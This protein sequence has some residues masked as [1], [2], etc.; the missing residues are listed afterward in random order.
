MNASTG[1][2][3]I[4]EMVGA[5][6]T[7][8]NTTGYGLIDINGSLS[9]FAYPAHTNETEADGINNLNQVVGEYND[10]DQAA[11]YGFLYVSGQYSLVNPA[12]PNSVGSGAFGINDAGWIVGTWW[13]S[14]GNAHCFLG[15]VHTTGAVATRANFSQF[16]E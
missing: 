5:Y 10:L 2:P 12:D 11:G 9:S 4:N 7:T 1:E 14:D 3:Q 16:E 15:P 8:D 6:W 13:D